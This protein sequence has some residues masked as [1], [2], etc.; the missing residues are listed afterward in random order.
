[1]HRTAQSE[2]LLSVLLL[3]MTRILKHALSYDADMSGTTQA[4]FTQCRVKVLI[5]I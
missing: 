2:R 5:F 1:M 4:A 3:S